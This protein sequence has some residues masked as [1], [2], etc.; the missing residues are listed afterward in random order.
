MTQVLGSTTTYFLFF[1]NVEYVVG[2]PCTF[3]FTNFEH[4][5]E[6]KTMTKAHGS[7]TT[8]FLFFLNVE[9]VVGL[10]CTFYFS[11]LSTW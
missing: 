10:P 1:L 3:Y 5:L 7:T 11:T 6:V 8:Y 4:I 9:Y 2:L